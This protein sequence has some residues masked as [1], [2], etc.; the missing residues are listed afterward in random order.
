MTRQTSLYLHCLQAQEAH[1]RRWIGQRTQHASNFKI[2]FYAGRYDPAFMSIFP[3]GDLTSYV[4]DEEVGHPLCCSALI[5]V[6]G[7][8]CQT[9]KC[10]MSA[11]ADVAVLEEPEHLTWFHHGIRWTSKF[12]HVTGIIHTNYVDYARRTAPAAAVGCSVEG[13]PSGKALLICAASASPVLVVADTNVSICRSILY[14]M[15][16]GA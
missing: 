1:V 16:T 9:Y 2:T 4:P 5:Q 11:Q 15:Q 6:P 8:Y 12:V 14:T 13:I 7:N 3:V 10:T